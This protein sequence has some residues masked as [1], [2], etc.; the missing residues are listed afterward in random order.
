M[1]RARL[2]T[3][4]SGLGGIRGSTPPH[5]ASSRACSLAPPSARVRAMRPQKVTSPQRHIVH[6]HSHG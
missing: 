1:R 6:A 2:V 3:F 4:Q 5:T